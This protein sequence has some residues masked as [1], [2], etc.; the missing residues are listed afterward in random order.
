MTNTEQ[1]NDLPAR[2]VAAGSNAISDMDPAHRMNDWHPAAGRAVA[3]ALRL[4]ADSL[5]HDAADLHDNLH[6]QRAAGVEIAMRKALSIAE[7]IS[8]RQRDLDLHEAA[9]AQSQTT[10]LGTPDTDT[11]W[12]EQLV[13]MLRADADDMADAVDPEGPRPDPERVSGYEAAVERN[14]E[15]VHAFQPTV[16]RG[17]DARDAARRVSVKLRR[18]AH[19]QPS[20]V[21]ILA[22][23]V[24][25]HTAADGC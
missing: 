12:R 9:V 2:L 1:N 3:S 15:I 17:R 8:Q 19:V 7:E 13:Q 10:D 22:A 24:R 25:D 5:K 23:W 6:R 11:S 4:F 16:H 14:I 20:D 21:R 18:G